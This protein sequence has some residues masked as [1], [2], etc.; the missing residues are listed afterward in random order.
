MRYHARSAT[1]RVLVRASIASLTCALLLSACRPITNPFADEGRL[2]R[3]EINGDSVVQVG[4]TLRLSTYGR[5][6]GVVGILTY[7]RVLD[8]A[9]SASDPTIVSITPIKPPAGDST[10]TA[11]LLVRGV[12]A[13]SVQI[14]VSARGVHATAPVRVTP[15][16]GAS[17]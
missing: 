1:V 9:W 10:S 16:S 6:S 3:I 15:A 2:T 4:N 14:T 17:R 8:A 11:S 12:R 13:G 7:D 5:V